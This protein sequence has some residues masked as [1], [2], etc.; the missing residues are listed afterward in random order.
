MISSLYSEFSAYDK[1]SYEFKKKVATGQKINT[2][3]NI[4]RKFTKVTRHGLDPT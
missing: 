2:K 1:V 3:T 4:D